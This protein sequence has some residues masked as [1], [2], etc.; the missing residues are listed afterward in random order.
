MGKSVS[1]AQKNPISILI[2]EDVDE[3]RSLL[4]ETLG[5]ADGLKVS[6]QAR[7]GFEARMEVLKRRPDLVLLDEVLPGE[8]GLDLL[9]DFTEQGLPVILITGMEEVSVKL[10]KGALGR[11]GKPSWD[12]LEED[13]AR[14]RKAIFDLIL[15]DNAAK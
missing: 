13:R 12:S 8:S 1:Q 10:P 7:N 11:L 14:M 9:R 2:V 6:G 4:E 15:R 5:K 3:M